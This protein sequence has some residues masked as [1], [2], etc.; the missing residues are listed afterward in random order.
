MVSALAGCGSDGPSTTPATDDTPT[1]ETISPELSL[2]IQEF[3]A[4]PD[5]GTD[6]TAAIQ[7]ALDAATEGDTVYVPAGTY[8]VSA[9]NPSKGSVAA[10]AIDR[11]RHPNDLTIAGAGERSHIK[12]L[13]DHTKDHFLLRVFVR[14]GWTGLRIRDLKLDGNKSAQS[15]TDGGHG[16]HIGSA[17]AGHENDIRI[18]RCWLVN[19]NQTNLSI[20]QIN[21][22]RVLNVTANDA[23]SDHGISYHGSEDEG[24]LRGEIKRCYVSGNGI[25][26]I[27]CSQGHV[28]VE[29]CVFENNGWGSKTTSDCESATYRRVRFKDNDNFGYQRVPIPTPGKRASVTLDNCVADGN[30]RAG[31]RFGMDTN[32][33]VNTIVAVGNN[34]SGTGDGNIE[35][36][37]NAVIDAN[38]IGSF[39][40]ANGVGL[41][42]EQS[43]STEVSRYRHFGNP[44]GPLGGTIENVAIG[45]EI[46]GASMGTTPANTTDVSPPTGAA[47]A[48][49]DDLLLQELE[50]L[51]VPAPRDVGAA[52][53]NR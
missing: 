7:R 19:A 27:D 23:G 31:Y 10:L 53:A 12:L 2:N 9:A 4:T 45:I 1:D 38:E 43:V 44:A 22:I 17:N 21:G 50:T 52:S 41:Y 37:D 36:R 25:Y 26:G 47:V 42:L 13:G 46:V 8:H 35:V 6:D 28:L 39:W 33:D 34:R 48:S 18:E 15:A 16:L 20:R 51:D 3:G 11:D 5:D 30:G 14:D 32:Y 24:P 49:V 40:A 29:D